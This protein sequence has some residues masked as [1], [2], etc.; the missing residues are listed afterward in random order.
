MEAVFFSES[1]RQIDAFHSSP[2]HD[3]HVNTIQLLITV[4]AIVGVIV[5]VLL[6]IVPSLIDYPRGR[7]QDDSDPPAPTPL[8]P[9]DRQGDDSIDLAA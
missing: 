7:D 3:C 4:V 6:A 8:K 2:R 5:V 9:A 1:Q